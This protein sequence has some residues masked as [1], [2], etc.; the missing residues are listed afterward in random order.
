MTQSASAEESITYTIETGPDVSFAAV[1]RDIYHAWD[2]C[3]RPGSDLHR[4]ALEMGLVAADAD[5]NAPRGISVSKSSAGM[6]HSTVE[7]VVTI[8]TGSAAVNAVGR[9]AATVCEDLW[10]TVILPRVQQKF[11]VGVLK[12]RRKDEKTREER[13]GDE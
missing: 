6:D 4:E 7:L 12:E 11:G 10:K 2:E 1:A 8:L 13:S 9:G 5:V 3:H